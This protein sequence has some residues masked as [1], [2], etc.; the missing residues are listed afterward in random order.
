[1]LYI[2]HHGKVVFRNFAVKVM[3]PFPEILKSTIID[4]K[5]PD[6]KDEIWTP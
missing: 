4:L 6:M 3:I 1:M 2:F 5:I